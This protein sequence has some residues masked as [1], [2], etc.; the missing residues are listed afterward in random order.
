MLIGIV[1]VT[2]NNN[3]NVLFLTISLFVSL[4]VHVS[5]FSPFLFDCWWLWFHLLFARISP[6]FI[7]FGVVK[8]GSVGGSNPLS[9]MS[10]MVRV[11]LRNV[12]KISD[13]LTSDIV[14][15]LFRCFRVVVY[16]VLVH[17]ISGTV[18]LL[19]FV[20][21]LHLLLILLECFL[22]FIPLI[23]SWSYYSIFLIRN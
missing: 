16:S 3:V 14:W 2:I 17:I 20:K 10:Q 8:A 13:L 21:S 23:C 5:V 1:Q 7:L 22:L 15:L 9:R 18:F 19:C 4:C 11:A 12:S 6:L